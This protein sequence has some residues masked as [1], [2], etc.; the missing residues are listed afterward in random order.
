MVYQK[1]LRGLGSLGAL[2]FVACAGAGALEEQERE[3]FDSKARSPAALS[4]DARSPS[5]DLV[6]RTP[7]AATAECTISPDC[8]S[9]PLPLLTLEPCCTATTTCGFELNSVDPEQRETVAAAVGLGE[10]ET[11]APRERFFI[12]HPGAE[13]L[14]VSTEAGKDIL[15]TT[16]CS[17]ASILSINFVGCCLPNNR[18]GVSTYG[19]WDT[20]AVLAPGAG[21]ARLECVSSKKLNAQLADS[22][23]RGL[24]F[25]P[26]TDAACDYAALDA[27]LPPDDSLIPIPY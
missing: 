20:L 26:D 9:V 21:F 3:A 10:G 7:D 25:L 17:T 19:I 6:P 4:V 16:G 23:F 11:C 27:Q 24:R 18:C 5:P 22:Q 1:M 14:R 8:E 13:D 12:R 2:G 15:L